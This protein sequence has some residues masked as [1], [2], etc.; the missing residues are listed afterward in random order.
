MAKVKEWLETGLTVVLALIGVI[1]LIPIYI[2]TLCA[3]V[4]FVGARCAGNI[5]TAMTTMSAIGYAGYAMR[6]GLGFDADGKAVIIITVVM[7]ITVG[8]WD[9][10]AWA[11]WRW[12]PDWLEALLPDDDW[13]PELKLPEKVENWLEKFDR[14]SDIICYVLGALVILAIVAFPLAMGMDGMSIVLDGVLGLGV[15]FTAGAL[16]WPVI[17]LIGWLP[18][19]RKR[20]FDEFFCAATR[21]WQVVVLGDVPEDDQEPEDAPDERAGSE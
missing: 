14:K 4:A 15:A 9:L 3:N 10:A 21:N 12:R 17:V 11:L 6:N 5:A 13:L 16:A 20:K 1:I 7:I 18:R 8:L 19:C 2:L